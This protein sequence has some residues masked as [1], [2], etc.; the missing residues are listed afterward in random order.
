MMCNKNKSLY[1]IYIFLFSFFLAL[2]SGNTVLAQ[3]YNFI[4]YNVENGLTQSQVTSFAQTTSNELLIGTFGGLSVF[5]GTE[6]YSIGKGNGLPHNLVKA[7]TTDTKWNIWVG[8]SNVI[9]RYDGKKFKIYYPDKSLGDNAQMQLF[10]DAANTIWALID[11]KLYYFGSEQ[12]VP[13]QSNDTITACTL[14]KNG[15]LWYFAYKKGVFSVLDK[16]PKQQINTTGSQI[17]FARALHFGRQSGDLYLNTNKGIF[18]YQM[19]ELIPA[20]EF[21]E[22]PQNTYSS[23]LEDAKGNTWLAAQDGGVWMYNG[24][25]WEHYNFSNGLTDDWVNA[26]FEDKEGCIWIGTNGSGVYKYTGSVFV[27]YNRNTGVASPSIM[28]IAQDD[29]KQLYVGSNSSGLYTIK[30]GTL[31]KLTLPRVA[32]RINALLFSINQQLWLGTSQGG[33]WQYKAGKANR[34]EHVADLGINDISHL[35]VA[36]NGLWV[37]SLNGLCY[38]ENNKVTEHLKNIQIQSSC[39]VGKDSLLIGTLK[40]AYLYFVDKKELSKQ[41]VVANSTTLCFVVKG[42]DVFIGTDDKGV[43]IWHKDRNAFSRIDKQSG[44]TCDYIYSL[45]CDRYGNIWAGTGCGIDRISFTDKGKFA[46]KSFGKSDGLLGVENNANASFEDAE[47]YIWFGTTKGLFRY[48]PYMG[49]QVQRP[50]VVVIQSVQLFSKKLESGKY[51]DSLLPYLHFEWN[52]VLPAQQNHLTFSFRAISMANPEK[53]K[54]RYQLIGVDKT[55][56]EANNNYV[57]YPNL[58]P[59]E[60]LFKV[61]ASDAE[62]Q[63]YDNAALY[64]FVI[65][66]PYYNTVAFKLGVGLLFIGLFLAGVYIRNRNKEARRKWQEQLREQEQAAVRKKTAEDFHDEIGNKLTRI[67]LLTTIAQ[68]KLGQPNGDINGLLTQIQTNVASLYH[69]AK[70]IIWSLQPE[71]DFLSEILFR[72]KQNT[73]ELLQDSN[74]Q[75][76]YKEDAHLNTKIKLPTDYSRNLIMIFKEAV[77]NVVKHANASELILEVKKT[78]QQIVISL[79][80]NGKGMP[81][82]LIKGNGLGNMENRAKRIGATLSIDGAELEGTTL[83]LIFSVKE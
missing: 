39:I 65:K 13:F 15:V 37:A 53:I 64:P 59:G 24:L 68:S 34:L 80:D 5:D 69:G 73:N 3:K 17:G 79:K 75:F 54:Y 18:R 25:N 7:V 1:A 27:Y 51:S 41:P 57:V 61:W 32:D 26:I 76:L 31:H 9:T 33:L 49:T 50:P 60:Y 62:G 55:F 2:I 48:N 38:V 16:K 46:I 74:I 58:P 71:S 30:E 35:S 67:N 6:F 81:E 66:A 44:L 63:W 45:L 20:K 19:G 77:T 29:K 28:S 70:D 43:I 52:P 47:G 10:T 36:E 40:G 72:I 21:N 83:S 82:S 23:L 4:N 56:T 42:N 22:L 78:Q 11:F 8:T 14:D 12:F